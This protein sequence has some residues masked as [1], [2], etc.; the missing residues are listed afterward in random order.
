MTRPRTAS[1]L[2]ALAASLLA[3]ACST[4]GPQGPAAPP[5]AAAPSAPAAVPAFRAWSEEFAARW[6]R[7]SP[8]SSTFIQ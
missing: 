1:R 2:M 5:A 8:E 4:P 7:R 6:M 3:A